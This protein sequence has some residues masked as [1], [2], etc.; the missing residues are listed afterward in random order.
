MKKCSRN[1]QLRTACEGQSIVR[2]NSYIRE[3]VRKWVPP[4]SLMRSACSPQGDGEEEGV[5]KRILSMMASVEIY[6][7]HAHR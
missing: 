4:C 1:D 3:M 7:F 5:C 2:A 6:I